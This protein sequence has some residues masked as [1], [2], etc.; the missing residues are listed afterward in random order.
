MRTRLT[1]VASETANVISKNRNLIR[2]LADNP[3]ALTVGQK[4]LVW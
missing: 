3:T 2:E 1:I 4:T